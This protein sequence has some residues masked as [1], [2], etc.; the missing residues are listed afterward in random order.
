VSRKLL[1]HVVERVIGDA[2]SEQNLLTGCF[3]LALPLSLM[4][5]KAATEQKSKN[6]N[7]SET[8]PEMGMAL[9]GSR[10]PVPQNSVFQAGRRGLTR[11]GLP[12]FLLK[13]IHRL[14]LH[15]RTPFRERTLSNGLLP[16]R[17]A[18]SG[19]VADGS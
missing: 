2:Q 8:L 16:W 3:A 1:I 11:K 6:K 10:A 4:P 18:A 17:G 12:K 14:K 7:S 19:R 5:G 9:R 15:A 13:L